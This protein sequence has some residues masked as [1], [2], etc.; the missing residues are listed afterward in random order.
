MKNILLTYGPFEKKE[1]WMDFFDDYYYIKSTNKELNNKEVKDFFKERLII[2]DGEDNF[3]IIYNN[4]I[5]NK[6]NFE[7]TINYISQDVL[8]DNFCYLL[9]Y[10]QQCSKLNKIKSINNYT[11]YLTK[12]ITKFYAVAAKFKFWYNILNKKDKPIP[13]YLQLHNPM[14]NRVLYIWPNL[15]HFSLPDIDE[16]YILASQCRENFHSQPL[17]TYNNNISKILFILSTSILLTFFY[18]FWKKIPRPRY[19][20]IKTSYGKI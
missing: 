4:L 5:I 6:Q 7:E 8:K 10:M 11:F 17:K 20:Q 15:F 16:N 1:E 13:F 18:L 19:F 12:Q 2:I 3:F 9:N 14:K